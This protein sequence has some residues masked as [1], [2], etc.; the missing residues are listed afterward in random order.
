MGVT[1]SSDFGAVSALSGQQERLRL[2]L[3][4]LIICGYH[5]LA[6]FQQMRLRCLRLLL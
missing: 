2:V 4:W 1:H 5:Q 6:H 3:V